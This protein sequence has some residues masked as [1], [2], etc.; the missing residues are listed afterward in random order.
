MIIYTTIPYNLSFEQKGKSV[1]IMF[2][3]KSLQQII[4]EK[5]QKKNELK[6][7]ETNLKEYLSEIDFSAF[8]DLNYDELKSIEENIRYS[9][10]SEQRETLKQLLMLKKEEKYPEIKGAHYFPDLQKLTHLSQQEQRELDEVLYN[11]QKSIKIKALSEELLTHLL[12]I[13]IVNRLYLFRCGCEEKWD[14]E[15]KIFN[16]SQ[17][18]EYFNY[19]ELKKNNE[20]IPKELT[21][22]LNYG[23]INLYCTD[24]DC[25]DNVGGEIGINSLELYKKYPPHIYYQIVIEPNLTYHRL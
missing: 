7:C 21:E 11:Q 16:E 25:E 5:E 12:N 14:C 6:I 17:M 9:T 18:K 19:W 20:E 1:I 15:T 23:F 10:P 22:K 2:N 3:L 4:Q 8:K 24:T 13:G